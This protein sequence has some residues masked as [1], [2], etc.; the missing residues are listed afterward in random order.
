MEGE[1][2]GDGGF[3]GNVGGFGVACDVEGEVG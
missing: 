3:R 1:V 2:G